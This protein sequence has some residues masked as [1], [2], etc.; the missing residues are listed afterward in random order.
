MQNT[1]FIAQAPNYVG[2]TWTLRLNDRGWGCDW[3]EDATLPAAFVVTDDNGRGDEFDNGACVMH[4]LRWHPGL[5]PADGQPTQ[6]ARTYRVH[7]SATRG[8]FAK[9]QSDTRYGNEFDAWYAAQTP[10]RINAGNTWG[11]VYE[12]S[13]EHFR[14]TGHRRFVYANAAGV[15]FVVHVLAQ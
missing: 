13:V 8:D 12:S 1:D 10:A 2:G 11:L 15:R 5:W 4:A 7:S 6:Y 3:C 9:V 14:R